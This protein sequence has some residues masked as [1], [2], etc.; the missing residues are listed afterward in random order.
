M[1]LGEDGEQE[2]RQAPS[3][4]VEVDG[5]VAAAFPAAVPR[6]AEFAEATAE[7]DARFGIGGEEVHERLTLGFRHRRLGRTEEFGGLHHGHQHSARPQGIRHW[8]MCQWLMGLEAEC[9]VGRVKVGLRGDPATGL[10][11]GLLAGGGWRRG[12]SQVRTEKKSGARFARSFMVGR[13]EYPKTCSIHCCREELFSQAVLTFIKYSTEA[14]K[15]C[16][17]S[18]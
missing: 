16:C 7:G 14:I 9:G 5:A 2:N 18:K 6:E 8:R 3:R 12:R 15:T 4:C 17:A 13:S 11:R 1:V 10:T